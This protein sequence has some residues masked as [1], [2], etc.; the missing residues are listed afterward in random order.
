MSSSLPE[1]VLAV[2]VPVAV[3]VLVVIALSISSE[4]LLDFLTH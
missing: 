4:L 3:G 2:V 1:A